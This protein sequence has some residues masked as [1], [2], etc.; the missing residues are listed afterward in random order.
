M[1]GK[2]SVIRIAEKFH[3]D[4]KRV[5]MIKSGVYRLVSNSGR[6]Y[7]LK[8]MNY[9]LRY[10]KWM[11]VSLRELRQQGFRKLAWRNPHTPQGR[12]LFV[13]AHGNTAPYILTPWLLGRQ[14]VPTSKEDMNTCAKALAHFH[15]VGHL[16]KVSKTGK[17]NF[18]GKW[19]KILNARARVL[20][21]AVAKAKQS[22]GQSELDLILRKHG[23]ALLE[24]ANSAI[25]RLQQSPYHETCLESSPKITLCH[26]DSGPKNFV[27]T[28][29]G[30]AMIDFET[31]RID[32]RVYDLFRLIRL[33]GKK[34]D[35]DFSIAQTI[36]DSYRSVTELN[37]N[38]YDWLM[39][40]LE[41][42]H[43]VCKVLAHYQ[44]ATQAKKRALISKI[45]KAIRN[46]QK[47]QPFLQNLAAYAK[48]RGA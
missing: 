1:T 14:P 7:C 34:N 32:F 24:R 29:Q 33:A 36:L 12:I 23:D 38:E 10:L 37:S 45:R 42:P 30:P 18:A 6:Q 47:L 35:W 5:E 15:K 28:A 43:K 21:Q 20:K 25:S 13:R 19:P 8:R 44:R 27:L 48:E 26:G 2:R 39:V 40:W 11:D 22:R 41:F 46:E 16:I 4:V 31:L 17:Q 9:P 3:L